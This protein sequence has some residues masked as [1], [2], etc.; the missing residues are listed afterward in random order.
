MYLFLKNEHYKAVSTTLIRCFFWRWIEWNKSMII[1]TC[2]FTI[3]Q[4]FFDY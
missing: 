3:H 2:L 4:N 1:K